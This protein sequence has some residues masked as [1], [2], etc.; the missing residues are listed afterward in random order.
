MTSPSPLLIS[1]EG[2]LSDDPNE[3]ALSIHEQ[4]TRGLHD[5]QR[6]LGSG[7]ISDFFLKCNI[8]I[9]GRRKR[10]RMRLRIGYTHGSR[11]S[12]VILTRKKDA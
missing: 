9:R 3:I 11:L 2:R 7:Q 1:Q 5:L 6:G 4:I 12:M 8:L 10:L